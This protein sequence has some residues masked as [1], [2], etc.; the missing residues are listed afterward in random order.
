MIALL[1]VLLL[2]LLLLLL[3][4][5]MLMLLYAAALMLGRLIAPHCGLAVATVLLL[6]LLV[7]LLLLMLLL[8]LG[9]GRAYQASIRLSCPTSAIF[10]CTKR[11]HEESPRP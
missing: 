8:I 11:I 1:V 3:M 10:Y 2:L 7:L 4:L 5:V 6:V 9:F